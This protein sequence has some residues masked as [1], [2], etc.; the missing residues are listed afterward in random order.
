MGHEEL[1]NG[2]TQKKEMYLAIKICI[3]YNANRQKD[4]T[5]PCEQKTNPQIVWQYCLG[6]LLFFYSGKAPTRLFVVLSVTVK[7][8]DDV[9]AGYTSRNS[10]YKRYDKLHANTSSRCRV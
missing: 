8:F 5:V 3:C 1:K 2:E 10:D 9:V 7:P 4:M 6:I